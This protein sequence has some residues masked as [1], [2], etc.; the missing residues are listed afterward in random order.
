MNKA[1]DSF[2][3]LMKVNDVQLHSNLDPGPPQSYYSSIP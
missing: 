3:F 2:V 1:S